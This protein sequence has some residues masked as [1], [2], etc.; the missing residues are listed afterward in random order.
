M[1]SSIP[2]ILVA[3]TNTYVK[4]KTTSDS[5]CRLLKY[6]FMYGESL[7]MNDTFCHKTQQ[8]V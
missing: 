5:A 1:K 8:E 6:C 3:N 4:L 2:W 7:L